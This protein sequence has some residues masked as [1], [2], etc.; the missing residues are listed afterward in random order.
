MRNIEDI[1]KDFPQLADPSYHYLDSA[2]TSL[3]PASVIDA[4]GE[5]FTKYRANVH[6]GLFGEAVRATERYE[7][8]RKKVANFIGANDP[9]EVILTSGA[10]ESSNML[11]RMLEETFQWKGKK[12]N[13]VTTEMEHHSSL[14]PLQQLAA[15]AELELRHIPLNSETSKGSLSGNSQR[16]PL[17][18]SFELDHAAAEKLIDSNTLLVSVVLASNVT[19][20]INDVRRIADVASKHKAFFVVDATAAAGHFPINAQ[21]LGCDALYFSGHK[22]MAPTGIGVLWV[23]M[24]VL[25]G[26][27]PSQFGGHM[28]AHTD[29][30]KA[31]WGPIPD[32]FEAGTKN[33][34]GA[35][36]LGAAVDYLENIGVERVHENAAALAVEAAKELAKISGVRVV[37]PEDPIKNIG[38]ASF[39]ADWAHPHDIAEVLARDRVAVRAGHHCAEPL[40]T[41]LG[42]PATTRASFHIYN[43]KEDVDALVEGVK[44]ASEIFKS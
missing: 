41:A 38:I 4:V 17:D 10:T 1:R 2:A 32:R 21:K 23:K 34:A 44:K 26:L 5:Y 19:G 9:S 20:T 13:I 14:V 42:I 22:M 11:V 8:A 16:L 7:E 37:S 24:E 35:I 15:R 31:S 3:T 43:T 30:D 28:V 27:K 36:G 18:V 39:H 12:N 40:H 6:R 33:I 25:R 29:K